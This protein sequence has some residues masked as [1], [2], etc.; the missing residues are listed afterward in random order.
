MGNETE[1]FFKHVKNSQNTDVKPICC[2]VIICLLSHKRKQC[3]TIWI[4]EDELFHAK[5]TFDNIMQKFSAS[6]ACQKHNQNWQQ[7]FCELKKIKI[8]AIIIT[9]AWSEYS[10]LLT[11]KHNIEDNGKEHK[12]P[13]GCNVWSV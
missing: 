11:V 2:N 6:N 9:W 5:K 13:Q 12:V 1:I 4:H 8:L 7:K 10:K 3:R